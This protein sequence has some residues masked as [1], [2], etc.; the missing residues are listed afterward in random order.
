M[1]TADAA[2]NDIVECRILNNPYS[3]PELVSPAKL[4]VI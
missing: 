4:Q 3:D 2:E 1:M